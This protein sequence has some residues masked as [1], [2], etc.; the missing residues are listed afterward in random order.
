M[1]KF[2]VTTLSVAIAV[3]MCFHSATQVY[4]AD[5]GVMSGNSGSVITTGGVIAVGKVAK[6]GGALGGAA[7]V[8]S[9]IY[10]LSH[11]LTAQSSGGKVVQASLYGIDLT[12]AMCGL[13][14]G[15]AMIAAASITIV[16]GAMIATFTIGGVIA[17]IL[18]G[19]FNSEYGGSV[20]DSW[21]KVP[22]DTNAYKPNIYFYNDEDI[23]ISVSFGKDNL[24]KKTIPDYRNGWSFSLIDNVINMDGQQ[25][26]YLFYES[27][28]NP[29]LFN[30]DSAFV[31]SRENRADT[32][33]EILTAY[34]FNEQEI[35]D[36]VE[37]WTVKLD[38]NKVY[39]MFAE[40]TEL[41]DVAMPIN[42][43]PV[44]NSITRIW[45]AFTSTQ[46]AEVLNPDFNL[47]PV[48]EP[49]VRDGYTMVEWG[50]FIVE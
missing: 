32:F 11:G 4:K 20:L 2:I 39:L 10:S 45:F 33:R 27:L 17:S 16:P 29:K 21:F 42:V 13:A 30:Y 37:F 1:K 7:G 48:I 25:Y 46:A 28:T 34:N 44:P 47:N 3:V 36:F 50:G 8:G 19:F 6:V 26:S 43:D 35:E 31:I 22:E 24:L 12:F 5:E 15:I 49:V 40:G 14:I 18:T 38:P 41:V 9:D 23:D